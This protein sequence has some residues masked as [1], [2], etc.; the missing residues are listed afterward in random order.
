M[1]KSIHNLSIVICSFLQSSPVNEH[2]CW[3]DL[4][5]DVG[6]QVRISN[7]YKRSVSHLKHEILV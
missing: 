5:K 4:F 3:S 6:T 2:I 7:V 1:Y